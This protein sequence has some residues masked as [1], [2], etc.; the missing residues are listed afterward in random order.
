MQCKK[1]RAMLPAPPAPIG[2]A[3][4]HIIAILL[5]NEAGSLAR[6]AGLFSSRA[7]NIESLSV[8]PT[9]NSTVSRLTLVTTGNDGVLAQIVSQLRK[10]VDVVKVEDLTGGVHLERE[11]LLVKLKVTPTAIEGLTRIITESDARILSGAL[12]NFIVEVTSNEAQASQ[13]LAQVSQF[14]EVLE[15]VRSGA[16]GIR[17]DSVVTP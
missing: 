15:V 8:A 6:V 14:G 2:P 4:R 7:Y 10:L 12:A 1:I 5:Q 16:L 3:M 9:E 17:Q 11:L 13:F